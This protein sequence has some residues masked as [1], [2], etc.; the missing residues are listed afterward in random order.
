[1]FGGRDELLEL[2]HQRGPRPSR[3][4][5]S[6]S[7]KLPASRTT[8]FLH[9]SRNPEVLGLL[10]WVCSMAYTIVAM[11]TPRTRVSTSTRTWCDPPRRGTVALRIPAKGSTGTYNFS[12]SSCLCRKGPTYSPRTARQRRQLPMPG[13]YRRQTPV[14]RYQ[15]RTCHLHARH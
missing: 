2:L 5:L 3:A 1:M 7:W 6:K 12:S 13:Q 11:T 10:V 15:L 8:P 14:A 9:P 4:P